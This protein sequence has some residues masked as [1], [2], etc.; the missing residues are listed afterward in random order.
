M[1]ETTSQPIVTDL[2]RFRADG[3]P[4]R[5][6]INVDG[7]DTIT[8]GQ[9]QRRVTRTVHT[10]LANGVGRGER[11]GLL[12]GG[13]DWI[14][15]AVAY[16]AV[17]SAGAT[18]VHLND[19]MPAQEIR[20]RLDECDSRRLIRGGDQATP[21]GFGGWSVTVAEI[22]SGDETPVSVEIGLHD[23]ADILYTSGTTGPAKGFTNPHGTLTFGRGP[24]G[25]QQFTN[26]TPLLAPM[27]LGTTSSATTVA[28]VALTA[29]AEVV[30]CRLDDV[31]R[32]GELIDRYR[33]GS[34]ML[35]PW[36]AMQM[37]AAR[38]DE[39]FDV[40]CVERIGIA[41]APMPP[42]VSLALLKVFPGA[43]LNTA[44][45]QSE[46]VPAVIVNTFDPA[47]PATL[48][49]PA[50]GTQLRVADEHGEPVPVGEVGEIW[51]RSEAP[52]RLYLDTERA[53]QTNVDGWIRTGD[54]GHTDAEGYL[55]L[56]DRGSDVL[57]VGGR[58]LSSV[59]IESALYE[60]PA[61]TQ[62]AVLPW[63]DA[64]RG[65]TIA[66]AVVLSDGEALP[67][68]SSFLAERLRPEQVP[69][70]VFVVDSLP[71]GVTGKVLKNEL[72]K[73]L[74]EQEEN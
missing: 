71:R 49:R 33:I 18:A 23:I 11:V 59:E 46:A 60:H 62:A 41:S 58:R 12:F 19:G 7:Q 15:Y 74:I 56:F 2:L 48:G 35:T 73:Q 17:L 61:V 20:R 72:R 24:A 10:L 27:P 5:V 50:P 70:H 65:Q 64:D 52:R 37:I 39:H 57:H 32:M 1:S 28:I 34:I 14:D 67:R 3:Y 6:A 40:G 25:L 66:A 69:S 36:I 31:V 30:V 43:Q 26:P 9:W 22:D 42:T 13:M 45:A 21:E 47:R 4:D 38:L 8:Y 63:G 29:T 16:L 68:V 51:L 54:F 44:Y 55:Y 53:K